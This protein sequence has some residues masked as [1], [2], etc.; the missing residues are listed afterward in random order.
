MLSF[1]L[2]IA[3]KD[4]EKKHTSPEVITLEGDIKVTNKS[5]TSNRHPNGDFSNSWM[6][7]WMTFSGKSS[8][9]VCSVDGEPIWVK[10]V[11]ESC[12]ICRKKNRPFELM[13]YPDTDKSEETYNQR[14]AHGAH[15]KYNGKIYIVP[16]CASDNT[17]LKDEEKE[18]TLNA[19]TILVEEV[20]PII[21]EE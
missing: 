6:K 14:E 7:Y 5:N 13:Y 15:V 16:M 10:G 11:E 1:S 21:D 19:G 3:K 17:S 20:D 4:F 9:F 18:I 2:F 12:R 8:F